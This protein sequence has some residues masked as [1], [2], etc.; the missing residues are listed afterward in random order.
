M[1]IHG[2]LAP[3]CLF[4]TDKLLIVDFRDEALADDSGEDGDN[5]EPDDEA[6]SLRRRRRRRRGWGL[7][8]GPLGA[9]GQKGVRRGPRRPLEPS[10]EFKTLHSDAISAFIERDYDRAGELVKKAIQINPEMFSA[11]SLLS[12]ILLAQGE[13][14]KAVTALFSGAHT[15]PKDPRVWATVAKLLLERAGDNRQPVLKDVIYCYSRVIEIDQKNLEVRFQRAAIYR[16]LGY[17]GRASTEYERLLRE[18]PY[19]TEILR[20]VAELSIDSN[21]PDKAI[22][23]YENAINHYQTHEDED[24]FVF[25]WSDVNICI[26]L[27]AFAHRHKEGLEMLKSLSRWVLG[28]KTD[29]MWEKFYEDDREWDADDSPR[30]IKTSGFEPGLYSRDSYGS[31][32]PLELRV[33]MGVFRL[34][35][36]PKYHD[37]AL[38]HFEWLSPDDTSAGARVYDYADLFREA[39]DAIREAGLFEEALRYYNPL[40]QV[41]EYLDLSFYMALG[42]CY[43]GCGKLEDAENCYLT[44]IE[45]DPKNVAAR[46]KL[47]KLYES[48]GMVDRAI[49]YVNEAVLL[50]RQEASAWAR[51]RR[52]D[53]R[54]EQLAVEFGYNDTNQLR[55]LSLRDSEYRGPSRKRHRPEEVEGDRVRMVPFLYE[56]MMELRPRMREGDA[57]ATEDWLDIADALLRDFRSNRVFYPIQR[58]V[59]FLG[60]D[61]GKKKKRGLDKPQTLLDEVEDMARR[62]QTSRGKMPSALI[63]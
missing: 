2:M 9:R 52:K 57:G 59:L 44:V 10:D 7:F 1:R 31:G 25:S 37:E 32:L 26:E 55:D 33:K 23:Y 47:A 43:Q 60:Y 63:G 4:A 24:G 17:N 19:D 54:I 42:E 5:G 38:N 34:N 51:G 29:S 16:E 39:A 36:G 61:K 53:I 15:R 6:A 21:E 46:L 41:T 62:L 28:R 30:R 13:T 48:I 49:K 8:A 18:L 56:K 3:L 11:H 35:M 20:H 50:G 27:Y 45:Y 14:D 12:E 40:L 58:K 22:G